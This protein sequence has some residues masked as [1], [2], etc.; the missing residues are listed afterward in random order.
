VHLVGGLATNF[1]LEHFLKTHFAEDYEERAS[2]GQLAENWLPLFILD[3]TM[4]PEEYI[5]LHVYEPR[6]VISEVPIN[7]VRYRLMVRRCLMG[8]CKFGVIMG[9]YDTGT[10]AN[11]ISTHS[12]DD[13]RFLLRLKGEC[14]FR[15]EER[16]G[17]DEYTVARVTWPESEGDYS[18]FDN[19]LQELKSESSS[20]NFDQAPE[21]PHHFLQWLPLQL[22]LTMNQKQNVSE[23]FCFF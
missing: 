18:F 11:I 8:S 4:L 23:L 17:L 3:S 2:S 5:T 7:F 14:I 21:D 16:Q 19:Y 6:F 22:S 13:G 20:I 9:G 15:V 12:F 10:L 1:L